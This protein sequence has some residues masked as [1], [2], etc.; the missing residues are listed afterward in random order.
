MFSAEIKQHLHSLPRMSH[1]TIIMTVIFL[2]V[3]SYYRWLW[4]SLETFVI[5]ID[6]HQQLFQDFAGHYYPMSQ[7]ILHTQ[8]PVPGYFYSAFFALVIIPFGYL[9]LP[10]ALWAW[11]L[12]QIVGLLSLYFL[13]LRRLMRLQFW[14]VIL[15]T[16]TFTL[17]FPLLHNFNWG[18]VSILLTV[19]VLGAFHASVEKKP[20]LAGTILAI[21]A[22]IKYYP[23]IF[24]GYFIIKRDFRACGSF[25]LALL[26][27]YMLIP[28][29]IMGM[30]T[31]VN[32]EKAAVS[33]I[34]GAN[35]IPLASNS[36]YIA[37]VVSRWINFL[38]Q[39]TITQPYLQLL[40]ATGYFVFLLNMAFIW[41]MQKQDRR[42]NYLL[43]LLL[44]FLSLP[45]IIKTSWPHYFSYLP[46]CQIAILVYL[47]SPSS[48][49]HLIKNVL[50]I[51]SL[52]SIACSSIPVF[53]F[54][55][56]WESYNAYGMLFIANLL[57]LASVYA[58]IFMR[59][60]H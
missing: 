20:I 47:R 3:F 44:T 8:L 11:G 35:W 15:Y 12:L 31:W 59:T 43:S 28:S 27:I 6:Y 42:D 21:A 17:S 53:T 25:V 41:L 49:A 57:L 7:A 34:S 23:I 18:Q 14:E 48:K 22:A 29:A 10:T 51:L 2:L 52:L 55:P 9:S 46:F 19:C 36:Q 45:F 32:F 16:G 4:G 40:A 38:F 5:S 56:N 33:S 26:V 39:Q 54:F 37:H 30:E 24:L 58:I 13:P 60:K 1:I 50:R